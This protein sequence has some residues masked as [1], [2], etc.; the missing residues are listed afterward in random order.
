R[1]RR[2]RPAGR[3]PPLSDIR[4]NEAHRPTASTSGAAPPSVGARLRTALVER[5]PL[6][7]QLRCAVEPKTLAA[8]V[9]VL[10]V[11]VGF[12]VHHFVSG[13]PQTVAAS[14]AAVTA[15]PLTRSD[16]SRVDGAAA[17]STDDGGPV[18]VDVAGG[19]RHPGVHRLPRG[20]RVADALKAAGGV[21]PGAAGKD[22]DALNQARRLVDGEQIL[23]GASARAA[24]VAAP[25]PVAGAPP[26]PGGAAPP[27]VSLSS[28]TAEQLETLPGVGPVLAR[29]I[30]DYRARHGGFTSVDQLRDVDGIGPSRF[31]DLEPEVGP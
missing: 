22:L 5:L 7:V 30:I 1:R 24:A 4:D 16:A 27:R 15:E 11:A 31:S 28:A 20:S 17:G 2:E 21:R 3:R 19:V 25:A 23:V 6:W 29:H 8:L 9:L 13:R 14:R 18:V 10:L 12:A 26:V